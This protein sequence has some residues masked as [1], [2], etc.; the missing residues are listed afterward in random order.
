MLLACIHQKVTAF[1]VGIF[2][3]CFN[4]LPFHQLKQYTPPSPFSC[5]NPYHWETFQSTSFSQIQ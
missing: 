3:L 5:Q 2:N 1:V 4:S